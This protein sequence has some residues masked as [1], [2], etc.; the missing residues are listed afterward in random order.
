MIRKLLLLVLCCLVL[1]AVPAQAAECAHEYVEKREEPGCEYSGL[2]WQECVLC[3]YKTGYTLLDPVGHSFAQWHVTT[4]PTCTR[5]G[6]QVRDCTVCGARETASVPPLGHTYEAEVRHPTCTAGGYTRFNCQFCTSYYIAD[7]TQPLGHSYNIILLREPTDTVRGQVRFTCTRCSESHVTY[8]T[9]RDIDSKAYYFTPVVWA[10]DAGITSGL[11]DT[12]FG[13]DALCNRAQVVTFLWRA[14]GKPEP[15]ISRNPFSDVPEGSFYEKAVLWA[16]E[17][18]ITTGTD[19][20]RFSPNAACN[21]AQVVTFLHRFRGCPEP[22]VTAAFPDVHA[23]SFYHQAVLWAAQRGITLGMD[24]GYFCPEL[25][26]SRAQ[27]VTF[28]YRDHMNP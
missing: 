28:L 14:A 21:R 13:P 9:F 16:Y 12:H 19:A 7:Y 27:I 17:R 11:D 8:Y 18:G 4:E 20:S 22:T 6:V 25:P 1:T 26:C 24:G 3:G 23:G 2:L 10:L 5:E 15:Q